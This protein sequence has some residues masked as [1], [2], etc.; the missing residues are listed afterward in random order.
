[1]IKIDFRFDSLILMKPVNV[2]VLLPSS[3][4]GKPPYKSVLMLH[5]AL[6]DAYTFTEQLNLF[7]IP[8]KY[9]CA[10]IIPSLPNSFFLDTKEGNYQ[11]FIEDE[12][13][14]VIKGNINIS[15]EISDSFL[16]GISMGAN[17]ALHLL[18]NG[19]VSFSKCALISGFYDFK[20]DYSKELRTKDRQSYLM[21]NI[22]KAKSNNLLCENNVLLDK[23][24]FENLFEK[25]DLQNIK[26]M[27]EIVCSCGSSDALCL[28]QNN[29]VYEKIKKINQNTTNKIFK[30]SHDTETFI[31]ATNFSFDSIFNKFDHT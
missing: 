4:K 11:S 25:S 1:M 2:L 5:Y 23:F 22:V 8:D 24:D 21:Y 18:L 17:A 28:S 29:F 27:Q 7:S 16:M 30:G 19:Q 10:L 12:L 14:S 3:L 13:L 20:T 26:N 6:A 31:K 9:G 15:E